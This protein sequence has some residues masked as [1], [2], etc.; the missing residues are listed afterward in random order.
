M[1]NLPDSSEKLVEK[2]TFRVI[3]ESS[4]SLSVCK[5]GTGIMQKVSKG[6]LPAQDTAAP[7]L[8]L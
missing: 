8:L 1:E 5:K 6:K 7:W 2:L 4:I 3:I